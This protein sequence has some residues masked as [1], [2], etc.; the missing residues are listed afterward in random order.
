MKALASMAIN[1][2]SSESKKPAPSIDQK[3]GWANP[4][5]VLVKRVSES[6]ERVKIDIDDDNPHFWLGYN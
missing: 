1:Y 4:P 6:S 5:L 3:Q 2:Q